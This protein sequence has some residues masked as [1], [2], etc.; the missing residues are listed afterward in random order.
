MRPFDVSERHVGFDEYDVA[1][2]GLV[3]HHFDLDA[4][5]YRHSSGMF[6]YVW[7][8]ELLVAE[9]AGMTLRERWGGWRREPYTSESR[10]HVSV[11]RTGQYAG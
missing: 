4:G 1:N 2:Q 7:P 10:S 5:R 11:W 8:S 6:R 3:S 9:L